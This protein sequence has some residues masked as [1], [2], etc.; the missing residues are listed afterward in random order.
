V[1]AYRDTDAIVDVEPGRL[2]HRLD[3]VDQMARQ[4]LPLAVGL[5]A[6]STCAEALALAVRAG[7][8]P[9]QKISR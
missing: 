3:L 2:A 1:S 9:A 8:A 5:T 7:R 6:K 4:S